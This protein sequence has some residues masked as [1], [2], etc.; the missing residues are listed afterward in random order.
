MTFA[1]NP[2]S[3]YSSARVNTKLSCADF[4]AVYNAVFAEGF[5]VSGLDTIDNSSPLAGGDV[6]NKCLEQVKRR[7]H[8]L[9]EHGFKIVCV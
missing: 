9:V 8:M 4:A 6:R 5:T 3:L 2:L 1:V 7:P